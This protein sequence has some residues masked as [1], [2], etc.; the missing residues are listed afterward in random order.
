MQAEVRKAA[1]YLLLIFI[2]KYERID[3]IV[4]GYLAKVRESPDQWKQIQKIIHSFQSL[5]V[6]EPKCLTYPLDFTPL[7]DFLRLVLASRIHTHALI[8]KAS[9][10]VN[11]I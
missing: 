11:P 4:K 9:E 5:L 3:E 2:K 6:I 10:Q 7:D 1:H 8:Q